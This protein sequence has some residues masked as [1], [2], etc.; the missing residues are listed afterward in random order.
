M[1]TAGLSTNTDS[2]AVFD[3]YAS[4]MSI[5]FTILGSPGDDNALLLEVN[6]GQAVHQLL[7]DCGQGCVSSLGFAQIQA[8]EHLFFSHLHTD[9][10]AGFDAFFR[11]NFARDSKP[12]H[13]WGPRQT[14][15]IMQHRF[16]GFLWN[17]HGESQ[18]TWRV[19]DVLEAS[20]ETTRFELA[21]A[22]ENAYPDGTRDR[23][24][25]MLETQDFT[26][27]TIEM[28][29]LTPSLAYVVREPLRTNLDP[30]KLSALGL[31]PGAWVKDLKNPLPGRTTVEIDGQERDLE[32]SRNELLVTVPG[33][34]IAYLTDFLLDEAALEKLEGP[35]SGCR[36][37][38]CE[39]QYRHADLELAR[40]NHHMTA[41]LA[42]TLAERA[43]A[44]ELI[45]FHISDRYT[46]D[47]WRE[48]LLEARSVFANTRFPEHWNLA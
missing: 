19:H 3:R 30:T 17:L 14:S 34:S 39:S 43:Q 8:I 1:L 13:I 47:E 23:T 46:P 32:S 44:T 6:S 29:H 18:A 22:F 24:A 20:V 10:V 37:I 25:V 36:T 48:L 33:D 12:N 42:A 45:L 38:V 28:D 41:I 40:K 11:A 9:H 2:S 35:L 27:Q 7:F 4:R 15:Q 31:K 5:G 21:E 26:V 16:Q